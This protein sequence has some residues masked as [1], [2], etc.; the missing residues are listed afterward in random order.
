M[1]NQVR[2]WATG[3]GGDQDQSHGQCRRQIQYPGNNTCN[4]WQGNNLHGQTGKYRFGGN[5]DL[6]KMNRLQRK[7]HAEHDN[8]QRN[9]QENSSQI[10]GFQGTDSDI[11]IIVLSRNGNDIEYSVVG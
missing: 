1:C 7:P 2:G 11:V 6:A 8:G 10:R 3:A 9:R 4:Q 5:H